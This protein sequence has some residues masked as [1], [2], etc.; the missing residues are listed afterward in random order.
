MLFHRQISPHS[1]EALIFYI[2]IVALIFYIKLAG[3]ACK[4]FY[5]FFLLLPV[6]VRLETL[7]QMVTLLLLLLCFV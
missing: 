5:Q 2:R 7:L 3:H 6:H 1:F 4:K